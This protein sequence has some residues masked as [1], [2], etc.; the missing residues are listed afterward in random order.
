[1]SWGDARLPCGHDRHELLSVE[2]PHYRA[3]PV[4]REV[5]PAG[6][7]SASNVDPGV[8][9]GPGLGGIWEVFL[10]V[11]MATAR[12]NAT[13]I[14]VNLMRRSVAKKL[15]SAEFGSHVAVQ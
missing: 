7:G 3:I 15:L 6:G 5:P 10:D 9:L 12:T 13:A 2:P 8:P 1:V 11:R 14:T 4:V